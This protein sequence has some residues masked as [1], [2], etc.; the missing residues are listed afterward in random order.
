MG[1]RRPT[2][3][4][5][6][7]NSPAE[8]E[9]LR[10]RRLEFPPR[11]RSI[12]T[13]DFLV[14]WFFPYR[15][16]VVPNPYPERDTEVG[17]M[18]GNWYTNALEVAEYVRTQFRPIGSYTHRFRDTYYDTTLPYWFVQR[19]T[20]PASTLATETVQW[21]R[22][23]RFWGWEGVGSCLGTCGHVYNA[24]QA[25]ARLFPDLARSIRLLQDLGPAFD[26]ETGRIGFRGVKGTSTAVTTGNWGYAAD[27][28]CG[29]VLKLYREH[30][31]S[32]DRGFLDR[33]WPQT[34][35]ALEYLIGHDGNEDG[36]IEDKQHTTWDMDLFGP[37]SY[38]GTYYLAALRAGE[39]MARIQGEELPVAD[40]VSPALRTRTALHPREALERRILHPPAASRDPESRDDHRL[41]GPA[42]FPTSSPAKPGPIKRASAVFIRGIGPG[43]HCEASTA[44]T[45]R[46]MSLLIPPIPT[47]D[48]GTPSTLASACSRCRAKPACSSAPGRKALPRRSPSFT[49][50]RCGPEPNIRWRR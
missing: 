23:G 49:M 50:R 20:M 13:A 26:P 12:Q 36:I 47:L 22:N 34:R 28:Q 37:N 6:R 46:R 45:G 24:A 2:R 32:P 48:H 44:T 41:P 14:T 19:V 8:R 16:L 7:E 42:V 17:N 27:A 33:I 30:L 21:W 40:T 9:A 3:E 31:L 1:S 43:R 15:V 39:E 11:P 25:H 4:R 10:Q 38:M 29:Y 18:Y 5:G 35:K